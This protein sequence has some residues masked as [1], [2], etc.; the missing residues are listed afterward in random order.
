MHRFWTLELL[1]EVVHGHLN[2]LSKT[3][4]GTLTKED[5]LAKIPT[6]TRKRRGN[7]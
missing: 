5:V 7:V 6:V 3:T 1:E 2:G 4:D